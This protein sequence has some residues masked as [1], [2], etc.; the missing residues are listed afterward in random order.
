MAL[1]TVKTL[2]LGMNLRRYAL[3]I[4]MLT[5]RAFAFAAGSP[6]ADLPGGQLIVVVADGWN[7][8]KATMYVYKRSGHKWKLKFSNPVVL[9][10]KGLG[11]GDGLIKSD[12]S[13]GPIK[14]EGDNRSPAGIFSI[15]T[16]F[17]YADKHDARWIHNPY[18]KCTDTVICVDDAH[19]A[20]YNHIISTDSTKNDWN[21][22]EHMLLKA[23]YYKW[24]LFVNHNAPN[25]VA[26]DGSCIFIH[27]WGNDHEGTSGCTAMSEQNILRLLHWIRADK[28]PLLV[29]MPRESYEKVRGE[30]GLP[31]LGE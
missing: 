27:I 17:G 2:Y 31:V 3:L 7:T 22:Y 15:G 18:V 24:G 8:L 12:I 6:P 13:G 11:I 20:S 1:E 29:Q 26:G 14:H 4:L 9:G 5:G 19:S 30:L 23:D 25:A 21:S 28:H 16:A 10:A